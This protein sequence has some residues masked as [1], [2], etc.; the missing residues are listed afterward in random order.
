MDRQGPL[1]FTDAKIDPGRIVDHRNDSEWI[2]LEGCESWTMADHAIAHLGLASCPVC[3]SN[4]DN[5][6]GKRYCA[7]CDRTSLDGRA[8]FPGLKVG[9][10]MN[11]EWEREYPEEGSRQVNYSPDPALKGGVEAKPATL[12]R[13]VAR[14]R[15]AG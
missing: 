15:T 10:V 3:K 2:F 5:L 4:P 12:R 9:Q 11:E 6:K 8:R 13:G 7:G 14:S 1:T